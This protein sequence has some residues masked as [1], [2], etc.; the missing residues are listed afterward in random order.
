ML[1]LIFG[2][3][4]IAPEANWRRGWDVAQVFMMLVG[5]T[6][7]ALTSA[8]AFKYVPYFNRTLV[9]I[10]VCLFLFAELTTIRWIWREKMGS[11]WRARDRKTL[12]DFGSYHLGAEIASLMVM[13]SAALDS[14]IPYLAHFILAVL[15]G[16]AIAML[17]VLG[18]AVYLAIWPSRLE[19]EAV[20]GD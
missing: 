18:R 8:I 10:T 11:N 20:H 9:D 12:M 7:G 14:Q 13:F 17:T 16:Y 15:V 5:I 2:K 3:R 1:E 4:A 19:M 6:V